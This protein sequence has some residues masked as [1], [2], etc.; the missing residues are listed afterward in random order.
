M[1][2]VEEKTK[3]QDLLWK[4]KDLFQLPGQDLGHTNIMSHKIKLKPDS[5]VF[6]SQPYRSNPRIREEISKQ[7]QD[8]L[9]K[10]II[11]ASDSPYLSPVVMVRK[12]DGVLILVN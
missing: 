11:S 7:V 9:N 8:M 10:G 6:R 4:Y 1:L 2:D 5:Q 12:P 3:L